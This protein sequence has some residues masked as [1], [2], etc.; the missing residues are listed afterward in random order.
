MRLIIFLIAYFALSFALPAN[1]AEVRPFGASGIVLEGEIVQGDYAKLLVL[2]DKA[3]GGIDRVSLYS[4]GG[5]VFEAIKMGTL[6]RDLRLRAM[7]PSGFGSRGNIC[8]GIANQKNCTCLSACV[9][10]FAGGVHHY[11]NVLGVHRSYVGHDFDKY[12]RATHGINASQQLMYTVNDYLKNMG[13]PQAFIETMNAT[14][15]QDISFL[16]EGEINRYLSGYMPQFGERVMAKCGKSSDLL[17]SHDQLELKRRSTGL[18]AAEQ[19]QYKSLRMA[20]MRSFQQC[21]QVAEKNMR[22][23]V[24]Y[25]VM[26]DARKKTLSRANKLI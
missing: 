22:N 12:M 24:F 19:Q 21:Q 16:R 17:R 8:T 18:S 3:G 25:R 10:V 14:R 2:L 9:L 1:A 4:K 15:S 13:F 20:N 7:A 26:Q 11:G 5:S 6:I 23:E